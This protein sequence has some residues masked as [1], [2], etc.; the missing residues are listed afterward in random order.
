MLGNDGQVRRPKTNGRSRLKL[1]GTDGIAG[2]L[3]FGGYHSDRVVPNNH[4]FPLPT[5]DEP[6]TVTVQDIAITAFEGESDKKM[7]IAQQITRPFPAVLDSTTPYIYLPQEAYSRILEHFNLTLDSSTGHILLSE[8]Q[9]H[10][11]EAQG[12]SLVF[13]ISGYAN[14]QLI[15]LRDTVQIVLPPSSLIMQ[16]DFPHVPAPAWYLPIRI[17]NVSISNY[18]LGR[19]FLQEAYLVAHYENYYFKVHQVD[20]ENAK[21]F[22]K[23]SIRSNVLELPP[24]EI[25]HSTAIIVASIASMVGMILISIYSWCILRRRAWQMSQHEAQEAQETRSQTTRVMEMDSTALCEMETTGPTEADGSPVHEMSDKN[26]TP[27]EPAELDSMERKLFELEGNQSSFVRREIE[28]IPA[29]P[30][31]QTPLEYYG[32]QIPAA[33][34]DRALARLRSAERGELPTDMV[35]NA[36][37]PI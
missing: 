29:S 34:M 21:N 18:V 3:V 32:T 8:E 31:P 15:T 1:L 25:Q 6:L 17:G 35:R 28:E 2:A 7:I 4:K 20:W 14:K 19:T 22:S 9:K 26:E 37:V 12:F 24:T 5:H 23:E 30:I 16:L 10:S 11:F 33:R 27:R 36:G 13:K